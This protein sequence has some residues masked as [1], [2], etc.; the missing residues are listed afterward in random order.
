[1]LVLISLY[2]L[3]TAI[4]PIP[5][6]MYAPAGDDTAMDEPGEASGDAADETP[7][8]GDDQQRPKMLVLGVA[9]SGVASQERQREGSDVDAIEPCGGDQGLAG[10]EV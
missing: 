9:R 8:D 6:P 3:E 5:E 7:P 2:A 10:T 4:A 1:M